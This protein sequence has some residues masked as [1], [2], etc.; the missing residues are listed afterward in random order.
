MSNHLG[1]EYVL[2][3]IF[4]R[5]TR[6]ISENNTSKR[7]SGGSLLQKKQL[8]RRKKSLFCK[9][10]SRQIDLFLNQIP[11]V[12]EKEMKIVVYTSLSFSENMFWSCKK[13]NIIAL[14]VNPS[15]KGGQ[16]IRL[17]LNYVID[18]IPSNET[19]KNNY[20]FGLWVISKFLLFWVVRDLG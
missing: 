4:P 1:V 18:L 11:T 9:Q 17:E 13:K 10:L 2:W 6:S 19:N 12:K 5:N 16:K 3:S 15:G 20:N 14:G 7:K 8:L